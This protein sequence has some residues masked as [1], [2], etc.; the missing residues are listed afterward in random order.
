MPADGG[1]GRE[2]RGWAGVRKPPKEEIAGRI[3]SRFGGAAVL[4][5]DL[6]ATRD[7]GFEAR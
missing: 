2:R 3:G 5:R 4:Y 6:S 1:R 7:F